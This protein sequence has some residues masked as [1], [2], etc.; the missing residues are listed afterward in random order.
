MGSGSEEAAPLLLPVAAATATAEERCPGCVQERR[1]ASR[2]GRIP[3]TELFFVAVTTLASSL[4]ITCLFPF[5]YFMVRDLQVA[6]TEEDIGYYAGF[7]GNFFSKPIQNIYKNG[8]G[9]Q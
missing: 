5:L 9:D 7:L 6:Q 8:Y 2:G 3:Y 1:K 4:P